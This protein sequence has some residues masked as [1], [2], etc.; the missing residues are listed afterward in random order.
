MADNGSDKRQ[1]TKR[2][3]VRF[4]SMEEALLRMH[5]GRTGLTIA[6]YIRKAVLDMPPPPSGHCPSID[7]QMTAQLIAAM[8]DAASAFRHAAHL[9]DADLVETAISDLGE[10]RIVLFESMG[11]AP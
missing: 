7:R 8:G 10:Y 9:A 6:S 5:A 2:Y 3:T 11:R 1:R 4:S